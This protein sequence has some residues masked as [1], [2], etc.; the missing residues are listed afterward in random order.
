VRK[1][2]SHYFPVV[3]GGEVAKYGFTFYMGLNIGW[4]FGGVALFYNKINCNNRKQK[5]AH[6][7]WTK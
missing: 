6:Q 5:L 3:K 2:L 4:V 7:N 1:T